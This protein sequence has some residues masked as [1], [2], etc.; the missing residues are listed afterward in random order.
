MP[1]EKSSQ[2]ATGDSNEQHFAISRAN[3]TSEQKPEMSK[4]GT[5]NPSSIRQTARSWRGKLTVEKATKWSQLLLV[6][7]SCGAL[8]IYYCQLAVMQGQLREIRDSGKQTDKLLSLYRGQLEQLTK[9]TTNSEI[10]ARNASRQADALQNLTLATTK[11]AN[12]AVLQSRTSANQLQASE[13]PWITVDASIATD[14][15]YLSGTANISIRF[16]LTNYGHS[17]AINVSVHP[18]LFPMPTDIMKRQKDIC[19]DDRDNFGPGSAAANSIFPTHKEEVT[20]GLTIGPDIRLPS[21]MEGRMM[22]ELTGCVTYDSSFDNKVH[23]TGFLYSLGRIDPTEP[24]NH[25]IPINIDTPIR[26]LT[27]DPWLLPF[28][29]FAN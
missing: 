20:F 5:G 8:L 10:L 14:L 26:S 3:A 1:E 9:Q 17:P 19:R 2:D 15:V 22:P 4:S 27:L 7:I 18:E 25:A 13:R 6:A 29:R 11:S 23:Q 21:T 24:R 16:V 28:G 12:A